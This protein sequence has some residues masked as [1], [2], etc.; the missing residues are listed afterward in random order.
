MKAILNP[1][2]GR[3][4]VADNCCRQFAVGFDGFV[5]RLAAHKVASINSD[6][7]NL[8]HVLNFIKYALPRTGHPPPSPGDEF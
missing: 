1:L 7:V 4:I 3:I 2:V 5:Q 8:R 6:I